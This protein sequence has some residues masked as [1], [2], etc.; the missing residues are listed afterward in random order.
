MNFKPVR[1]IGQQQQG[2]ALSSAA[3]VV[4]NF[5]TQSQADPTGFHVNVIEI[6]GTAQTAND[7]GA[8][9]NAILVDT[10]SL[11][12][13]KI[14]DTISLAAINAEVDSALN[15]ALPGTPTA[16]SINDYIKRVKFMICNKWTINETT[17]ASD[18]HD[19]SDVL[20]STK[21]GAFASL[22]GVTTREKVI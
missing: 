11:N 3:D 22:A 4:D 2:S 14:P 13:T 20:F 8:D 19:D 6:G 10:N 16:G 9:I 18:I 1:E 15:T 12:D 17:G 7:N 5:E 21:A